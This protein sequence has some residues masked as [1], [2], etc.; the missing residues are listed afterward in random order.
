MYSGHLWDWYTDLGA[1][2]GHEVA[3][4]DFNFIKSNYFEMVQ[5][6][7]MQIKEEKMR[8]KKVETKE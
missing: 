2:T 8:H 3:I 6:T 7:K 5:K 4:N 1:Q